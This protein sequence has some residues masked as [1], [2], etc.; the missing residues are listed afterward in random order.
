MIYTTLFFESFFFF[1]CDCT[2]EMTDENQYEYIFLRDQIIDFSKCRKNFFK[3]TTKYF[4]NKSN[5]FLE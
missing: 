1:C 2:I 3:T 5:I 4:G